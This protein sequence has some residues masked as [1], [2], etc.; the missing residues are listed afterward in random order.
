[1]EFIIIGII[2]VLLFIWIIVVQ[3][4]LTGMDENVNNAM[5]QIGVQIS[6]RFDALT[7]LLDITK[8]YADCESQTLTVTAETCC[9]AIRATST[10]EEVLKQER[11][12]G[13]IL[14][15]IS[16]VAECCPELKADE[17]YTKCRKALDRYE[18]MVHTSRLIYNDSVSRFNR[19][20]RRFP[21]CVLA[22]AFGFQQREHLE[23][24]EEKIA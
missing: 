18:N 21:T 14:H 22:L 10:P 6:S 19:E 15:C 5:S 7:V 17:N 3:R 20:L 16:I 11:V 9:N 24:I 12:I 8:R 23:E 4:R 1:M 2:I 13:E